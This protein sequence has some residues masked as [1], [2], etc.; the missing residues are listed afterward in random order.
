M[1][2]RIL[3]KTRPF[4]SRALRDSLGPQ[5]G[6][7]YSIKHDYSAHKPYRFSH[8]NRKTTIFLLLTNP[9]DVRIDSL[10]PPEGAWSAEY[11]IKHDYSA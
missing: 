9:T 10:N 11:S 6:A 5:G 4:C 2:C 8:A 3:D 1:G 7:E